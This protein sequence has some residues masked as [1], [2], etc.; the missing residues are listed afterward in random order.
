MAAGRNQERLDGVASLSENIQTWC[1]VLEASSDAEELI[2]HT[3]N[4]LGRID[5]LIN[6][7]G[8]IK[9]GNA[10]DTSDDDWRATMAT[11]VDV[12]FYLSRA[13]IPH[14][15]TSKGSII[16]TGS[17]WG[18]HAGKDA[19]A[20]CVSKAA[21]VM[22]SKA[23]AL[24]PMVVMA[25]VLMLFALVTPVRLCCLVSLALIQTWILAVSLSKKYCVKEV[26]MGVLAIQMK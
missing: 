11:N 9:R 10:I 13:A 22:M 12:P 8:I 16:N 1:G 18:L 17:D 26:L 4:A 23:M 7:A 20:Y 2:T 15:K 5:C 19:T 6:N 3:V 25:F 21:I 14:L 24:D